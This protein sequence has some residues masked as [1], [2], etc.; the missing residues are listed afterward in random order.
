M[1]V[2]LDLLG[3]RMRKSRDLWL[4]TREIGNLLVEVEAVYDVRAA[5]YNLVVRVGDELWA[6]AQ[7]EDA[8]KEA[9]AQIESVAMELINAINEPTDQLDGLGLKA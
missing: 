4:I 6:V 2:E 9:I 5:L 7:S 3:E 1:P 8:I